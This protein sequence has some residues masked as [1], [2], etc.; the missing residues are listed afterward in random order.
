MEAEF[1]KIVWDATIEHFTE[2]EIDKILADIKWRLAENGVLSDYTIVEKGDGSKHIHQ[3]EYE[4]KNKEDLYRFFEP[5][6]KHFV[7]FETIYPSRHNLYFWA[8]D[9]VF[10]FQEGW[11]HWVHR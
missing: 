2:H 6:F 7:V 4:F 11:P 1:E 10:P 9:S 8:S 5:H 3:S